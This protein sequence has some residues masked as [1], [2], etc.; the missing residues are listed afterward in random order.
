MSL[1]DSTVIVDTTASKRKENEISQLS[2][3][4]VS[5]EVAE[6]K[7]DSSYVLMQNKT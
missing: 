6:M 5:N 2:S 1:N 4:C 3:K 7:N